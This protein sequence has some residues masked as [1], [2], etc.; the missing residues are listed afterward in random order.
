MHGILFVLLMSIL[1]VSPVTAFARDTEHFYSAEQ[2]VQSERG[3][4]HL[5]RI[6][7]YLKGQEH[8]PV[9]TPLVE[10]TT[11]QSTRGAFRSDEASC[12]VAFL[13]AVR[14]LQERAQANDGDA[15]IDIVS[16]TRDE[17]TESSTQFR[18]VAGSM[19]VNVG[20]RGTVVEL[21]SGE[22]GN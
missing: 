20:L 9:K 17:Q 18:C 8:P 7:F 11:S 19:V 4:A 5:L 22:P 21:S 10:V 13:S 3:R 2:A 12:R 16:V 14:V 1:L 15:I 6:P